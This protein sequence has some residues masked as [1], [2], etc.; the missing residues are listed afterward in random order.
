MLLSGAAGRGWSAADARNRGDGERGA[1]F[2]ECDTS[3]LEL[4]VS[5]HCI[6]GSGCGSASDTARA[7]IRTA[8]SS[9]LE[10]RSRL[11]RSTRESGSSAKE[12]KPCRAQGHEQLRIKARAE[13]V[14]ADVRARQGVRWSALAAV[15]PSQASSLTSLGL[16][17]LAERGPAAYRDRSAAGPLKAPPPCRLRSDVEIS[18]AATR[19]LAVHLVLARPAVQPRS[20]AAQR[21]WHGSPPC[22]P[23]VQRRAQARRV[24]QRRPR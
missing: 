13:P 5:E 1:N 4:A 3:A 6:S 17:R 2:T 19:A 16:G 7:A 20:P 24:V 23:V 12:R 8:G 22:E 10:R 14:R 18:R 15:G 21:R 11:K 9:G